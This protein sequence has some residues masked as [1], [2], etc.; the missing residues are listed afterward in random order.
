MSERLRSRFLRQ[1]GLRLLPA[2]LTALLVLP[3]WPVCAGDIG[4]DAS[5]LEA[6]AALESN[7]HEKAFLLFQ[8][9]AREG[10]AYAQYQIGVMHAIGQGVAPDTVQA[11]RWYLRAAEQEHSGRNT[12]SRCITKGEKGLRRTSKKRL[13]GIG[14]PQNSAMPWRRI[15]SA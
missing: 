12:I 14:E 5:L 7:D 13:D 4:D 8:Q 9:L 6:N 2:I 10:D 15:T 3:A 11:I 1:Y